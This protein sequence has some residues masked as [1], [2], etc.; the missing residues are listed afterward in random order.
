MI[1]LLSILIPMLV[2]IGLYLFGKNM[3]NKMLGAISTVSLFIS[4]ALI[5]L[6]YGTDTLET[7]AWISPLGINFS[8][9]SDGLSWPIALA[10][11]LL[12][13]LVSIYS[14]G[15][16]KGGHD[17]HSYYANLLL[18]VAAMYG[19]VLAADLIEFYV[20]WELML[21]PSY[22]LISFWGHENAKGAGYKYIIYTHFG[23]IFLLISVFMLWLYSGTTDMFA[24]AAALHAPVWAF[25]I[26]IVFMLLGFLIKMGVFPFHTWLPDAPANAPTPITVLLTG[27][28]VSPGG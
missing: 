3:S 24:L 1:L 22:L 9:Y 17:L 6:V 10:I 18:F 28:M 7:Y 19:V 20:F 13:A 12:G 26:I 8:L 4:L 5:M 25:Q 11:L 23:A 14:V 16:I 27:V 21:I 2:G 15:Y